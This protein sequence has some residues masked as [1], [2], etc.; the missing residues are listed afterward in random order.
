VDDH[1]IVPPPKDVKTAKARLEQAKSGDF[2]CYDWWL[3]HKK[4]E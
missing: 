1:V 4:L 2:A 3:C